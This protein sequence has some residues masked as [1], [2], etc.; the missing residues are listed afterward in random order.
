MTLRLGLGVECARRLVEQQHPRVAHERARDRQPLALATREPGAAFADHGV[1]AL[2]LRLDDL[3]RVRVAQ[4]GEHPVVAHLAEAVGDVL[5]D[6][7]LEEHRLL[8]HDGHE[9]AERAQ[10]ELLHVDAVEQHPPAGRPQEAE[11]EVE[12]RRLAGARRADERDRLARPD[13]ERHVVERRR[14]AEVVA[15]VDV[16]EPQVAGHL[17]RRRACPR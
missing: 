16:L 14:D 4:G 8:R 11:H 10:V 2:R 6:R 7:A 3:E 17:G 5:A 13:L 12:E 1:P 15:V 9:P